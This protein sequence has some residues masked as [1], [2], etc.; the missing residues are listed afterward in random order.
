[1]IEKLVTSW[2]SA[3]GSLVAIVITASFAVNQI[4]HE[5]EE[6]LKIVETKISSHLRYLKHANTIWDDKT[7]K[8]PKI[9]ETLL[10][11]REHHD[12]YLTILSK[13]E[14][15]WE[16]IK[17]YLSSYIEDHDAGSIH[18]GDAFL[19]ENNID[20]INDYIET[21]LK[22][23]SADNK[24]KVEIKELNFLSTITNVSNNIELMNNYTE[25]E[26]LKKKIKRLSKLRF[27][28]TLLSLAS[29]T[30]LAV[31]YLSQILSYHGEEYASYL[32]LLTSIIV[33]LFILVL[34]V[35]INTGGKEVAYLV[36]G[37]LLFT[38]AVI[39]AKYNKEV[40]LP[41]IDTIQW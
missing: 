29:I 17:Y 1:M 18:A 41:N 35:I 36:A 9:K 31:A 39:F 23:L 14:L 24:K 26:T 27:L 16:Y 20:N 40:L 28:S 30:I 5:N 33:F 21:R 38:I 4:I 13:F 32:I 10:L 7:L 25:Y 6:R 34:L 11:D 2:T 8:K 22:I 12:T 37:I 19:S 15:Y 3:I